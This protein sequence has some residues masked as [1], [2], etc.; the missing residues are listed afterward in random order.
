MK[1]NEINFSNYNY[2]M[3]VDA[4]GDDGFHFKDKSCEGSS[5]TF[6]ASCFITIPEDILHN[7]H[8]L[9]DMK[10]ELNLSIDKELKSTTLK[11]HR[12]AAQAYSHISSLKGTAFSCIAFKRELKKLSPDICADNKSISS[13]TQSFPYYAI[14]Y[15]KVFRTTDKILIVMDNMKK[16]E[17]DKVKESLLSYSTL[18]NVSSNYTLIFRDSKTKKYELIQ[19]ADIIAGTLRTYFE[20]ELTVDLL[21]NCCRICTGHSRCDS[22]SVRKARNLKKINHNISDV[23][24]LHTH[25]LTQNQI[26]L[27]H[28]ITIPMKTFHYYKYIDCKLSNKKRS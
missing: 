9:S 16:I 27:K 28:I 6:V 5:Y 11:R 15:S 21:K 26:M 10:H 13:L 7:E 24:L 20:Q 17:M 1:E 22:P 2:I 23:F 25:K 18:N 14:N 19:I 12:F 3:F 8:V 4:S